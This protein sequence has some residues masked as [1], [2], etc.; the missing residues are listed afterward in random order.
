MKAGAQ[1]GRPAGRYIRP[2]TEPIILQAKHL[3]WL[4]RKLC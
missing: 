3:L 2:R 4:G 1:L